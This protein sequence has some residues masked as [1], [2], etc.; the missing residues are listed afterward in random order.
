M[1]QSLADRGPAALPTARRPAG[2]KATDY[3]YDYLK[4][5]VIDWVVPAETFITEMEVAEAAGLS[6]T[7]VREAFLRLD[8][9]KLVQLVPRRGIWIKPVTVR[10]IRELSQTRLVLE[11]HAAAEV[12]THRL[13]A[14]PRLH[15]HIAH[16]REMLAANT[17]YPQFIACDR[18]FHTDLVRAVG[19]TVMT[20]IYESMGDRQQHTGVAAFTAQPGR[21]ANAV[22]QHQAIADAISAR[23]LP[24][25]E[26]ALRIHLHDCTD[27]LERYLPH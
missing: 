23:D 20:G 24:A 26:Q 17:G 14:A 4:R 6:R 18:Q 16:Q 3:A 22:E 5:L 15:E 12:I 25:A 1:S 7:P 13:D 9:E 27:E 19:N 21:A 10:E 8:A 11:L 2:A